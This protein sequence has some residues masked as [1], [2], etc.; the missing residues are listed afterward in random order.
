MRADTRAMW[1]RAD[2]RVAGEVRRLERRMSGMLT[3]VILDT[4]FSIDAAGLMSIDARIL[5]TA[6]SQLPILSIS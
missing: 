5:F 6:I 3:N 1:V 2:T 4:R